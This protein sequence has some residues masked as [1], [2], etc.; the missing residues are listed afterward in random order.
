MNQTEL[1][2]YRHAADDIV[3]TLRKHGLFEAA[4]IAENAFKSRA[5]ELEMKC[6]VIN[7]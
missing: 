2:A 3:K 4:R 7:L 5:Q 1:N 6:D